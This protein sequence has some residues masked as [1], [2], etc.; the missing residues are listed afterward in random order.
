MTGSPVGQ[1]HIETVAALFKLLDAEVLDAETISATYD[2]PHNRAAT[3]LEKGAMLGF[4]GEL[5]DGSYKLMPRGERLLLTI[6]TRG[7]SI[8]P[9]AGGLRGTQ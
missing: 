8:S 2:F 1:V 5:P 9:T 6:K 4:F 7:G 3:V